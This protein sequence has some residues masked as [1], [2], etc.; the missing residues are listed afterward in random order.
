MD[1]ATKERFSELWNT[2]FPGA[3]LPVTF[4]YTDKDDRAELVAPPTGFRCFIAQL[5]AVRKG[6]PRCFNGDSVGCRGGKRYLGFSDALMPKFDYFLSYG[7][8]G[9]IEGE[10][11][12]KSPELVAEIMKQMPTFTAPA[13][14]IVFKRWDQ[15]EPDDEPEVA[16]FFA[17]PDVISGL[18]TLANFDERDLHAVVAPFSAGCGSIVQY[19]YLEA[20][21][22]HPRAVLGMFD[23]SARPY[24]QADI[25][26]F[27][28]PMNKLG[29]MVDNMDESFL[30]TP[31]WN[32]IRERMAKVAD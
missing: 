30:I 32:R 6:R 9:M 8:P 19:P 26:T 27:A 31:A 4:Y 24:V 21:T 12:K 11:Y 7:I 3:D 28:V 15:L 14:Y 17:R 1:I 29:R 18:F 20:E 2:H 16:V 23:V 22:D 10:R 25:L 13:P 5:G